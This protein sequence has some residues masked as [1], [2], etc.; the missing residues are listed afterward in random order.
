VNYGVAGSVG[1]TV[2]LEPRSPWSHGPRL[3]RQMVPFVGRAS[4]PWGAK[5]ARED[6][7]NVAVRR[8]RLEGARQFSRFLVA[9]QSGVH[10]IVKRD[11]NPPRQLHRRLSFPLS[12]HPPVILLLQLDEN[13]RSPSPRHHVRPV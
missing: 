1:A 10:M 4:E 8:S 7:Q 9:G 6:Y 11:K 12:R 5:I 13:H 2:P 3:D